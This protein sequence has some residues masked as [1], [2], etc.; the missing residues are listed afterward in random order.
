MAGHPARDANA[1]GG[2]LLIADPHAGQAVNP[3]RI[4]AVVGRRANQHV[5][6]IAHV[7]V[8]VAAIGFEI[9]DRVADDLTGA[10]I[11]DVTAA[12]GL[13]HVDAPSGEQIGRGE[14][15]RSAAIASDAERQDVRVLDEDQ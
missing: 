7:A 12:A 11:R 3:V 10:M 2:E 15:M 5:F 14:N 4:D 1:D 9:E 6:E 8:H 13:V